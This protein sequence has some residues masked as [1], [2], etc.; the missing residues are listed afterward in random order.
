MG[1]ASGSVAG[2]PLRAP[3]W[4]CLWGVRKQR[5]GSQKPR[6]IGPEALEVS[7]A[8]PTPREAYEMVSKSEIPITCAGPP[9]EGPTPTDGVT[10]H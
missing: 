1:K 7:L 3:R 10:V 2:G 9:R 5:P 8:L 6:R 4:P